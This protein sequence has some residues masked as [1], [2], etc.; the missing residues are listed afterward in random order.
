MFFL[1]V[2]I[3]YFLPPP[4]RRRVAASCFTLKIRIIFCETGT[5]T[6]VASTQSTSIIYD[7]FISFLLLLQ[8]CYVAWCLFMW[9]WLCD[10][11]FNC[12]NDRDGEWLHN[13]ILLVWR[14]LLDSR[15]KVMTI[16]QFCIVACYFYGKIETF[17]KIWLRWMRWHWMSPRR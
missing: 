17:L 7:L 12:G 15:T 11:G 10:G 14:W 2:S 5:V 6:T 9:K 4:H 13:I 8:C 3:S 1:W 16:I